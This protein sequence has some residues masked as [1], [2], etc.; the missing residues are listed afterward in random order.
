MPL[1]TLKKTPY[2]LIKTELEWFLSGST[3]AQWLRDRGCHIWDANSSKETLDKLGLQ[4][5]EYDCG[6]IYGF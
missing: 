4:Y 3:D 2:G 6:P 1:L 5:R